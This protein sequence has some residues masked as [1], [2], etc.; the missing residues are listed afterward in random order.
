MLRWCLVGTGILLSTLLACGSEPLP[1]PDLTGT[2]TLDLT[3]DE[4]EGAS[5]TVNGATL[6]L[7]GSAA[8]LEGRIEG[9]TGSCSQEGVR[10][11]VMFGS[12]DG[13][14]IAFDL[15]LVGL[16]DPIYRLTGQATEVTLGGSLRSLSEGS[17][18]TGEWSARR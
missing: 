2:W 10:F 9:G 16:N 14:R 4:L 15:S 6:T 12:Q 13:P 5:C 3:F 18:V 7:T 11:D 8:A 17:G 1:E